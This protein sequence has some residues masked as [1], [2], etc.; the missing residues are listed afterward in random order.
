[1]IAAL[2]RFFLDMFGT[3]VT[4]AREFNAAVAMVATDAVKPELTLRVDDFAS[5]Q[6]RRV[7]ESLPV[8]SKSGALMVTREEILALDGWHGRAT[9][10]AKGPEPR[11]PLALI[12]ESNGL[13]QCLWV[14]DHLSGEP[15]KR[16]RVAFATW[17][18][19]RNLEAFESVCE[20]DIR[21]RLAV[22]A[23]RGWLKSPNEAN[24]TGLC[25]AAHSSH[26]AADEC[27]R[28]GY[29]QAK[30][31]AM[32]ADAITRSAKYA[33][34][35]IRSACSVRK[36]AWHTELETQIVGLRNLLAGRDP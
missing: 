17:C 21:P 9:Y 11:H 26:E 29:H 16:A 1:M 2:R 6:L 24:W 13:D 4:A 33:A 10:A 18:V 14:L 27:S 34:C 3:P 30:L 31:V 35:D 32:A 28:R 20:A 5:G 25:L 23:A 19:D 22:E 8:T 15:A 12:I 36:S 7:I